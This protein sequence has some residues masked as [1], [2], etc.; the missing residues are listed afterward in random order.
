MH[1]EGPRSHSTLRSRRAARA[2]R[3]AHFRMH[4]F[5]NDNFS[6]MTQLFRRING[7]SSNRF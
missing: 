2:K 5:R 6:G 1:S 3:L 7:P 4:T